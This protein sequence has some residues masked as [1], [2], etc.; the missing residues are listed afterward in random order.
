MTKEH[1]SGLAADWHHH[2]LGQADSMGMQGRAWMSCPHAH[3]GLH[4]ITHV[5]QWHMLRQTLAVCSHADAHGHIGT[6]M[7]MP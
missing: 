7:Q 1:P 5:Q 6:A 2:V 4:G 3:T